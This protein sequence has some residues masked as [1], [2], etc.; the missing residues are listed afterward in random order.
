[1]IGNDPNAPFN[2]AVAAGDGNAVLGNRIF[3][4]AG[5]AIDLGPNDGP[6][7]NNSAGHIGPNDFLNFPAITGA[8]SLDGL[9]LIAGSVSE[10]TPVAN[11]QIR[12]EF[13]S[14]SDTQARVFLG[15][16]V[17]TVDFRSTASFAEIFSVTSTAGDKLT[18]TATDLTTMNTSELAP[19]VT[20]L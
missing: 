7:P 10:F 16:I 13:F 12:I 3:A 19:L 11:R 15:A 6:T 17:V 4:N 1:M 9:T 8:F 14:T 18:A 5:Q 2:D 20:I